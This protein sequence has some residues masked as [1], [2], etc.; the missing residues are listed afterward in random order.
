MHAWLLLSQRIRIAS[1]HGLEFTATLDSARASFARIDEPSISISTSERCLSVKEGLAL[2]AHLSSEMAT[3]MEPQLEVDAHGAEEDEALLA[4][5][6][7]LFEL[8]F[9]LELTYD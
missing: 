8:K 6:S 4:A 1:V 3:T 9:L 5:P 2:S 7:T